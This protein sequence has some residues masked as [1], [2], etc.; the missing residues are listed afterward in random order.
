MSPSDPSPRSRRDLLRAAAA[1]GLAP[2]ILTPGLMTVSEA[3]AQGVA[4]KRGGTLTSLLT[5]EPPVLIPLVNTQGPTIYATTKMYQG[6]VQYSSSLEPVPELAKS[7]EISP[8]KL[9]YTFQLQPNVRFHDGKPCTSEDVV[10]SIMDFA[11][12][13]SSR[14]RSVFRNASLRRSSRASRS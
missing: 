3:L 13:L 12:T 10:F 7:W 4:P 9:V 1:A 6:L 11:M 14:A 5:P 8:D 2:A